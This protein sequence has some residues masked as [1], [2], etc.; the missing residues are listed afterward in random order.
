MI[1]A[2]VFQWAVARK[3]LAYPPQRVRRSRNTFVPGKYESAF[4]PIPEGER[5]VPFGVY[6]IT[7]KYKFSFLR[8]L[9]LAIAEWEAER[10]EFQSGTAPSVD[11]RKQQV[12][13]ARK[14]A[15]AS[16]SARV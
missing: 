13:S 9:E 6:M 4:E 11:R 8:Q 3:W 2:R 15:V 1:P 7:E 12:A 5:T 16:D 10:A 14:E